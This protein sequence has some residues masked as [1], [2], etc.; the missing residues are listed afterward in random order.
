MELK[1]IKYMFEHQLL[2]SWYYKDKGNFVAALV[3]EDSTLLFHIMGEICEKEHVRMPYTADMYSFEL[4][5][6]SEDVMLLRQSMPEPSDEPLCFRVYFM[7][8]RQFEKMG[9]YTVE[10]GQ[11]DDLYLCGWDAEGNHANYGGCPDGERPETDRIIDI[12]MGHFRKNGD[13]A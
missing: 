1:D 7:F 6:I 4:Y 13:K 5:G 11:G 9:Y 12:Y 8:D 2:P 3:Q 10:K